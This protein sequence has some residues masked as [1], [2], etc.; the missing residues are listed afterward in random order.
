MHDT[1]EDPSESSNRVEVLAVVLLPMS[2]SVPCADR[3]HCLGMF[4]PGPSVP[5]PY[6]A[7]D[8]L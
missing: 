6:D 5:Q 4:P 8:I 2:A 1:S 3:V 7:Q